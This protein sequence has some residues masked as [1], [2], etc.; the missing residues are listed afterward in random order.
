VTT[1]HLFS[2]NRPR[3]PAASLPIWLRNLAVLASLRQLPPGGVGP[4]A[5][6][7]KPRSKTAL[8]IFCLMAPLPSSGLQKRTQPPQTATR[9]A[10]GRRQRLAPSREFAIHH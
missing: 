5:C 10:D 7:R 6:C 2:P 1:T 3:K 9:D 4:G 8:G